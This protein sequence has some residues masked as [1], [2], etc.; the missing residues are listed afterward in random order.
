MFPG[1]YHDQLFR[2]EIFVKYPTAKP[3]RPS[4]K[5]VADMFFVDVMCEDDWSASRLVKK[6]KRCLPVMS[7]G[8]QNHQARL[9]ELEFKEEF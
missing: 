8:N 2:T 1:T 9:K 5:N 7:G 3:T 4:L 6:K